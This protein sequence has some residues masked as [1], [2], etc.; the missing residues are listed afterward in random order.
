M[1]GRYVIVGVADARSSWFSDLTRWSTSGLI[2][3]EYIKALSLDE[4]RALLGTGRKVSAL[5]VSDMTPGI[6][7]EFVALARKIDSAVVVV[8]S[9]GRHSDWDSLGV[10]C[11]MPQRFGP[12][13]L[14]E[15]L[16]RH[17]KRIDPTSRRSAGVAVD[18]GNE[19]ELGSL[20]AVTGAGGAGVSTLAMALTQGISAMTPHSMTALADLTRQ[21]DLAMYH[22]VGDVIPGLPELV[23]AHRG[24]TPDPE[25]VRELLFDIPERGYRVLLGQRRSRDSAAMRPLSTAAAIDGLRR[26]FETVVADVEAT[27]DGESDTGS[28][29]IES[30]NSA[31]RHAFGVADVVVLVVTGDLRGFRRLAHLINRLAAHGVAPS[32][33]IPV[34]NLAS[35]NIAVRASMTR[36]VAELNPLAEAIHP[37]VFIR[38]SRLIDEA[39]NTSRPFP[40]AICEPLARAVHGVL[41]NHERVRS[42]LPRVA[43]PLITRAPRSKVA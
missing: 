1:T 29:D 27:I 32:R 17:A 19:V 2:A 4:A 11:T 22:D 10:A 35:R 20:I 15:V 36:T 30:F 6:D 33:M 12:D 38:R 43:S 5:L 39:H 16:N 24:D 26:S 41:A 23:E 8:E 18:F 31:Q 21:S 7:R 25:L 28:L 42:D 34:V 40:G 3:A 37:P 14:S 13:E 9:G